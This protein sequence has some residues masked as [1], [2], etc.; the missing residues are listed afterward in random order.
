MAETTAEP[1][2]VKSTAV[3]SMLAALARDVLKL[4]G[5]GLITRGVANAD[6]VNEMAGLI[7]AAA[8]I[9]YSQLKTLWN[10][11]KLVTLAH[12]VPDEIAHVQP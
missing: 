5:A 2:L 4:A 3:W 7:V 11:R 12:V 10:H 6:Q 8:P 1:I 9:I